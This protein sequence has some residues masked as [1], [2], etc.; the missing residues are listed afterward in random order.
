MAER[1]RTEY[2]DNL[3]G[4]ISDTDLQRI[5]AKDF[6]DPFLE[7]IVGII[8][9]TGQVARITMPHDFWGKGI[10]TRAEI[11]HVFFCFFP[12]SLSGPPM[13]HPLWK[14]NSH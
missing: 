7:P 9:V 3:D 6:T 2:P 14:V 1:N 4:S 8:R 13:N 12:L 5:A 11:Q 10:D